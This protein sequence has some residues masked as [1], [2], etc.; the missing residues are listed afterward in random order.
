MVIVPAATPYLLKSFEERSEKKE[1]KSTGI[2]GKE[3]GGRMCTEYLLLGLYR[4]RRV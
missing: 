2:S 1:L 3:T 4:E